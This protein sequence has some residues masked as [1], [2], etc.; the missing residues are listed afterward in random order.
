[1][2][3]RFLLVLLAVAATTAM[4][5][6]V[7]P[8]QALE[9]ARSFMQRRQADG[10]RPRKAPRQDALQM[11][12][13][14]QENG[15]YLFNV[16]DDEGFVIVSNDDRTAPIVGYSD[17]GRLDPSALP[18]NMRWWLAEYARQIAWM[19]KN[20][21]TATQAGRAA[22]AP[23][24]A[25]ST[26]A[27][28]P[29]LSTMWDQTP[30]YNR[31]CPINSSG[32][33]ATGCV[34]TA[35]A[36]VMK[37]HKWPTSSTPTVDIPAYTDG[38]GHY[39]GPLAQNSVTFDWVNMRDMYDYFETDS[40]VE[41]TAVAKLMMYCGYS[42]NMNYSYSSGA[43]DFDIPYALTTYFDYKKETTQYL[44]RSFYS[45]ESWRDIIYHELFNKR[46]VIYGGQSVDN[47]HAFVCD[48]YKYEDE[49]DLFHINWGWSGIGNGYFL[50]SVLNPSEQGVGG[51]PSSAA[52]TFGQ[53]AI[54]GI[55]PSTG[56]G[57]VHE[58]VSSPV[59][60]DLTVNS[61]SVSHS[62]ITLGES[63]QVTLNVSNNGTRDYDGDLFL[64]DLTKGNTVGKT[65]EIPAG[66]T[67]D[68]V[69]SYQPSE[70]GSHDLGWAFPLK[71]GG[72]EFWG[73]LST[74]VTVE[75]AT[76][77][78]LTIASYTPQTATFDW[79]PK[80]T[81]SQWNL[82]Y[83]PVNLEKFDGV[84]LPTGWNI[85]D[86]DRDGHNWEVA[87]GKG[88][89]GSNCVAS[90]S[91]RSESLTPQ[92]WLRT[93]KINLGGSISF[94]A[95]G[96]GERFLI[97]VSTDGTNYSTIYYYISTTETPT[98]YSFDLSEY[99]GK[100]GYVVIE[101]SS[102]TTKTSE[103]WLYVDNFAIV[104]PGTSWTTVS[105]ITSKPYTLSGLE[106]GKNYEAQV[107]AVFN[108]G[109]KWSEEAIFSTPYGL[110]DN[111]LALATKN[112][113]WVSALNGETV[114]LWLYGRTLYKDG[115]WNTLCLPFNVTIA[116]SPLAGGETKVFNTTDS[117][118][119]D[120]G[121]KLTLAFSDA[122][123]TIPAGTP[124][125]IKWASGADLVNPIFT[126]VTVSDASNNA[127]SG[128]GYITFKGLT[129][130]EEITS[131]D[132][133]KLFLG[134]DD[135]LYAPKAGI[136]IGACRAYFQLN[137]I[138]MNSSLGGDVKAFVL[139][140]GDG[141]TTSI[142]YVNGLPQTGEAESWHTLDGRRLNG[143]P[144]QGGVYIHNGQ[145]IVI[146]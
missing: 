93:P 14:G 35:M 54:I 25:H 59:D 78:A 113:D 4:A 7:T 127:T 137:G 69:I 92:N 5:E 58:D 139:D 29:L 18:D 132:T 57:T 94:E 41:R 62:T 146:K 71:G 6:N 61:I 13:V 50:L 16:S 70:I 49:T 131:N 42:L 140:F 120:E 37:Y 45:Y 91:Y 116:G 95:W 15:L 142:Q 60:R 122:P 104:E 138:T 65:F 103:S 141:N 38:Y 102:G 98:R 53:D 108:D 111:D 11:Q 46:P 117:E 64:R 66:S 80:G 136:T 84:T 51:S 33:C 145:K 8:Q 26:D 85:Y 17:S 126:G 12:M 123:T 118:Y 2:R 24:R 40:E 82:R 79:T 39:L 106:A 23:R 68:C 110:A 19:D 76:P 115:S 77:S 20:G 32:N 34:A 83:R 129:N 89:D 109:G 22:S 74:T 99:A 114:D 31:L 143:R 55:Q 121:R 21:I 75:D 87:A 125:I 96:E 28:G 27:I 43:S 88:I 10:S 112:S 63:V 36:Q 100:E 134:S 9:Q 128:D 107:Q 105:G 52:Y 90:A 67:A 101:H 48:G 44:S 30:P 144:V 135:K 72:I 73:T 56:T 86:Q 47:G 81:A 124:F 1:M 133:G 119:D 130:A 3:R 97:W